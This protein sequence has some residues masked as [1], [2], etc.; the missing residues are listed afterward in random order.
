MQPLGPGGI[1]LVV[2]ASGVGKDTILA[3]AAA[4][5]GGEDGIVFVRRSI[6]RP[7]HDSEAFDAMTHEAFA[8]VCAAGGF[9][10]TWEAHGLSYGIPVSIELDIAAGRTVVVNASRKSVPLARRRFA[11]A[12]VVLV[13]C[14]TAVRAERMAARGR[15]T[16]A[17]IAGRLSRT[18]E[19]F[20]ASEADIV[21]DNSGLP[22][23]AVGQLIG[24]LRSFRSRPTA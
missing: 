18:V 23:S 22:K 16:A 1:V 2:G 20:D 14:A 19:E 5:L 4:Q 13:D 3:G 9:A 11:R 24:V 8:G 17:E 6:T 10:M 7:A 21:I 15:E 12:L